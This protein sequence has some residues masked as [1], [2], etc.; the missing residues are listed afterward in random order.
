MIPLAQLSNYRDPIINF[1]LNKRLGI[2]GNFKHRADLS[3]VRKRYTENFF[4]MFSLH[5]VMLQ[6]AVRKHN[7]YETNK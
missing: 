7:Y 5:R 6:Y 4:Q 1:L 2:R 3:E